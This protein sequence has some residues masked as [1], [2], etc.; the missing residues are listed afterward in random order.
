[1]TTQGTSTTCMHLG[2]NLCPNV[3]TLGVTNHLMCYL[4]PTSPVVCMVNTPM[5]TGCYVL[6]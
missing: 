4:S 6:R 2:N 1:M 5:T 3:H